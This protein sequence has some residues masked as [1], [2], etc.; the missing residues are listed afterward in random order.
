MV[1]RARGD[2]RRLAAASA[3]SGTGDWAATT[4]LSLAVYAKTGS[5]VWLAVSFLL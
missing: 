4:A 3:I 2:I 1:N 5:A